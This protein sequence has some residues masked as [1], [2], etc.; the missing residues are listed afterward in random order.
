ME[1]PFEVLVYLDETLVKNLSSLVLTGYIETI[2]LTQ[3]FDNTLSAGLTEGNR[4]E[5]GNQGSISKIEREGFKDKNK[6]EANN[7]LENYHYD[8]QLDSKRCVREERRVQTTYTTFVLN[9][10]LMSYFHE[11]NKLNH[12]EVDDVENDKIEVG[13]IIEIEGIIT[14]EGIISYVNSIISLIEGFGY[15]YLDEITKECKCCLNF[16][17]LYKMIIYFQKMLESNN[18]QDLIMKVGKGTVIL[19]V[20]TSNF[21]NSQYNAFDKINC[22]CTVVGKVIKTCK[23]KD[24]TIS[25]LRKTGQEEF[26][27]EFLKTASSLMECLRKN[28]IFVPKCPKLRFEKCAIQVMPLNIYM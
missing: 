4:T 21:M 20:S 26:Y 13:D 23:E 10:N 22:H 6:L 27:E 25:L 7:E 11:N 5:S 18:T 17:R 9:K 15:D 19:T 16:N 1:N 2:T 24:D 14:N 28:K 3:T 12:R 8:R